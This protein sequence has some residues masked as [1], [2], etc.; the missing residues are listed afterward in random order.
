MSPGNMH[1][2]KV[3]P[4]YGS[5]KLLIEFGPDASDQQFADDLC[6]VLKK[7]GFIMFSASNRIFHSIAEFNSPKGSLSIDADEWGFVW[8]H[9]EDDQ[10][11]I[12]YVDTLLQKSGLFEKDEVDFRDY[13]K[14]TSAESV[15][16]R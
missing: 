4:G 12:H 13:L 16:D 3:R 14:P 11:V 7:N 10:P 8:G 9:A 2:Y 6:S 1:K 15:L 5:S